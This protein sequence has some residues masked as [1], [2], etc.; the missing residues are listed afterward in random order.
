MSIEPVTRLFLIDGRGKRWYHADMTRRVPQ[1]E[2]KPMSIHIKRM[3]YAALCLALWMVLP[4]LTG[5]IPVIGKM[6]SPMHIPV[7]LCGFLCGWPWGLAVGLIAPV[8]RSL[9]FGMPAMYPDAIVMALELA[10]Y[11]AV[12][13]ALYRVLPRKPWSVF[14]TL[15]AAMLIGR[16]VWGVA[17]WALL[18][19]AGNTFTFSMF[20]AG[21]FIKAWPGILLHL[22]VVPPIVLAL[23]KAGLCLNNRRS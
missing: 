6:L 18:G 13:G 23:N 9:L 21:G 11:G 17:K 12:A 16:V 4:F 14:V 1:R 20:L 15:I 3:I 19:L 10:T 22:V 7:F 8:L 2:G 5:Q